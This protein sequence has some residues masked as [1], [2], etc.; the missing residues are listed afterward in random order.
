MQFLEHFKMPR[1]AISPSL[2]L[3]LFLNYCTTSSKTLLSSLFIFFQQRRSR[4]LEWAEVVINGYIQQWNVCHSSGTQVTWLE[5]AF[6]R[7]SEGPVFCLSCLPAEASVLWHNGQWA[8]TLHFHR[9]L[10]SAPRQKKVRWLIYTRSY[11]R[12]SKISERPPQS[13]LVH[14]LK[15]GRTFMARP[16]L[17][18]AGMWEV[19]VN[20]ERLVQCPS[21][22]L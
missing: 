16:S 21:I 17:T 20:G 1:E 22:L 4:T 19:R 15:E 8:P 10:L 13:G 7:M 3:I 14:F 9:R 18:S 12:L 5:T 11:M 2:R 6:V